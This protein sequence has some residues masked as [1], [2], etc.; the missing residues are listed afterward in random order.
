MNRDELRVGRRVFRKRRGPK[1]GMGVSSRRNDSQWEEMTVSG[2]KQGWL[3][4]GVAELK[5]QQKK[6]GES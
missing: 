2:K 5:D 3:R 1:G 4:G 6:R